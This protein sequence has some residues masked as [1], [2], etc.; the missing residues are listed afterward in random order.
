MF[1]SALGRNAGQRAWFYS[2][3]FPPTSAT[4]MSFWYFMYGQG[5]WVEIEPRSRKT[6]LNECAYS[7]I[8][9]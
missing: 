8:L 1:V 5:Q 6:E 7:V 3:Y 9:D 4:C 2:Q